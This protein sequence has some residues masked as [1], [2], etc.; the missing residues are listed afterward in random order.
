MDG[1]FILK[2]LDELQE[3]TEKINK[4]L[5]YRKKGTI[6]NYYLYWCGYFSYICKLKI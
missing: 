4:Q 1:F 5:G 3:D 6:P 2:Q